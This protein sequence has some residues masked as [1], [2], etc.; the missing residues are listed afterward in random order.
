MES[1]AEIVFEFH[2]RRVGAQSRRKDISNN[3]PG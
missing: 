1:D 3:Q 2:R